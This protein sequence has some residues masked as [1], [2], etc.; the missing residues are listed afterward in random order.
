VREHHQERPLLG[1]AAFLAA[2]SFVGDELPVEAVAAVLGLAASCLGLCLLARAGAR[3]V[4]GL[5]AAAFAAGAAGHA[6]E[7]EGYDRSALGRFVREQQPDAPV[8]VE[9]KALADARRVQERTQLLIAVERVR[10]RD[11]L[12]PLTG[13]ARVNVQDGAARLEVAQGEPLGLWAALR[14]PRGY[15][16]PGAFD[17]ALDARRRGIH[18]DGF[19]KSA[20]L[21]SRP[22]GAERGG[23]VGLVAAW[24]RAARRVI[25]SAVAP[26]DE[27]AL[28]RA[29]VLG[30]RAGLS[31]EANEAFRIAGT[32]HV[33]ALS[34]AQVALVA[35][36]LWLLLRRLRVAPLLGAAAL[37]AA[38]W[39]YALFVGADPPVVRAAV[40]AAFLALGKALDLDGDLANLLGGAA[41]AL[42]LHA[43]SAIGDPSF[44]LS[45]AATL[46]ILLLARAAA[47]CLPALRFQLGTLIAVSLS[48]QAALLPLLAM[49]FHR[50][51]PAA[52]LLNLLAGPLSA[53]VLLSGFAL[54]LVTALLPPLAPLV[55]D[56][57]WTFAHWL[58]RSGEAARAWPWLDVRVPTPSPQ[59]AALYV[60][61]LLLVARGRR[62][63]GAAAALG[64][65]VSLLVSGPSADGRLWLSVLDVGHGDALVLR[66]PAG[67]LLLVDAGP[68]S[69]SFDLGEAVVGPFLWSLGARRVGGLALTHADGD[70]VGGAPF[71]VKAF[72]VRSVFEGAAPQRDPRY[73]RLA[74]AL[75]DGPRRV[76]LRA[77]A[78]FD[79]DGVAIQVVGP[80]PGPPP[81]L[82]ANDQSLVL[83]LRFRAVSLLLMGDCERVC[84]ADLA[85]GRADILKVGHHGSATSTGETLLGQA[86]PRVALVSVG[87]NDAFGHPGRD[88]LR[89]LAAASADT[90][91]TDRDGTLTL[92]TDGARIWLTSHRS[93][94]LKTR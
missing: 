58:L 18:A 70:H 44:Q 47:A 29:M 5:W 87:A 76:S 35:G 81:R 13:V 56:A 88:V 12:R 59:Q 26:G 60:L 9:G 61:G 82:A 75:G 8:W 78:L 73:E 54:L 17:F 86:R 66:S 83:K 46:G 42:L 25:V 16:S 51:A 33:L 57:A 36:L 21:V 45:F 89:R 72:A 69:R 80:P 31:S 39:L 2:G 27:Q 92:A 7:R 94:V 3:V 77:G 11:G 24:R 1:L 50:L 53:A 20:A 30:D 63:A 6:V 38:V 64:A 65:L 74:R 22:G 52:V 32:Y 14:A 55:A 4:A 28:V 49:H 91:R 19:C 90:F 10:F 41:A 48:A 15:A 40:M 84:E 34:G 67:R 79:W 68:A 37:A 71:L 62:A 85:P 93:G 23:I 43:P